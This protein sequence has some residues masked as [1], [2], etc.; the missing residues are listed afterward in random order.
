MDFLVTRTLLMVRLKKGATIHFAVV[1]IG[2]QFSIADYWLN[3]KKIESH[4][5]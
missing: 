1:L 4:L 2:T 5:K 3:N